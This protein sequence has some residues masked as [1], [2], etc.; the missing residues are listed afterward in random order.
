MEYQKR[1][2]IE[3]HH[4]PWPTDARSQVYYVL[5]HIDE[6]L[7][8]ATTSTMVVSFGGMF[9]LRFDLDPAHDVDEVARAVVAQE[10]VDLIAVIR[11][12]TNRVP[13]V[14]RSYTIDL[15]SADGLYGMELG[16]QIGPPGEPD[17]WRTLTKSKG[18]CDYRWFPPPVHEPK[19][20]TI[21]KG[22]G[23]VGEA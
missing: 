15:E 9:G 14:K 23:P 16:Y 22:G 1:T 11:P 19:P 10:R 21:P 2:L 13:G 17:T 12:S 5:E 4:W 18:D 8:Q 6:Q 20:K 7:A 3:L